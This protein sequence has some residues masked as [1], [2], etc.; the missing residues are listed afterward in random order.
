VIPFHS[1][2]QE[3]KVS[4]TTDTL[5][6]EITNFVSLIHIPEGGR[7]RFQQR[8]LPQSVL[9]ICPALEFALWDTTNHIFTLIFPAY[10]RMDTLTFSFICKTDSLPDLITWGESALMF[11]NKHKTV[12][13]L[14]TPARNH[15]VRQNN[16]PLDSLIE[17]FYYIQILASKTI[18]I[19]TD[20]K[21][22]IHLQEEHILLEQKTDKYY[23]YF[24]G[25]FSSKKQASASLKYYR[26][27]MPDAFV[28]QF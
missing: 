7:V 26:Q 17:G 16:I 25:N 9:I 1:Y 6:N 8:L 23:K 28:R 11:E 27:Y 15:I 13:K 19:K 21:K 4:V 2:G 5:T 18:Q 3:M 20:V 24:I 10:S 22:L 12:E 14:N